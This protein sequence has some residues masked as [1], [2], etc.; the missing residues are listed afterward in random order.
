MPDLKKKETSKISFPQL[1]KIPKWLSDQPATYF[2][3]DT[4]YYPDG[5]SVFSNGTWFSGEIFNSTI[6]NGKIH[7]ATIHGDFFAVDS[8]FDN[9]T[10]KFADDIKS[11]ILKKCEIVD[12]V[13]N[14]KNATFYNSNIKNVKFFNVESK[15]PAEEIYYV[16]CT[17]VNLTL[18]HIRI[19]SGVIKNSRIKHGSLHCLK[20]VNCTLS[21]VFMFDCEVENSCVTNATLKSCFIY[22]SNLEKILSEKSTCSRCELV[23]VGGSSSLVINSRCI[24]SYFINSCFSNSTVKDTSIDHSTWL[25]GSWHSGTWIS[26][27][28]MRGEWNIGDIKIKIKPVS[29]HKYIKMG[30][31]GENHAIEKSRCNPKKLSLMAHKYHIPLIYMGG[32]LVF[33]AIN[34]D[35]AK[36]DMKK[37]KKMSALCSG[38]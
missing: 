32:Y 19:E 25:S 15:V 21:E 22:R 5:R 2:F 34:K 1:S 33:S 17:I 3:K 9:S 8:Q 38:I 37:L 29:L 16:N 14:I 4:T 12:S 10:I 20:L 26:G 27:S 18:S 11:F 36:E 7:N 35:Q 28:W 24:V 30:K 13:F 23:K 31:R 6:E